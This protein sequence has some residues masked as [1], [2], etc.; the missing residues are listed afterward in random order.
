MH[1]RIRCQ[2]QKQGP[3]GSWMLPLLP[4]RPHVAKQPRWKKPSDAPIKKHWENTRAPS[5][6]RLFRGI[7]PFSQRPSRCGLSLLTCRRAARL[8][9]WPEA[10]LALPC[11]RA[12]RRQAPGSCS[13]LHVMRPSTNIQSPASTVKLSTLSTID[14]SATLP[15]LPAFALL[16]SRVGLF[17]APSLNL[18]SFSLPFSFVMLETQSSGG[19]PVKL[20]WARG[21]L[22]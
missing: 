1:D 19:V 8:S 4:S 17:A 20:T 22:Y 18:W 5:L 9:H 10:C 12:S 11:P 7:F 6:A 21:R 16:T 13:Q 3:S 14:G 15:C 2:E